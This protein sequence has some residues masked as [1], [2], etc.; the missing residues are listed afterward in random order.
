MIICKFRIKILTYSQISKNKYFGGAWLSH[1]VKHVTLD[2][3]VT[4]SN[5][6]LAVKLTLKKEKKE[7]V[8]LP[9]IILLTEKKP[10]LTFFFLRFSNAYNQIRKVA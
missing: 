3:G 10:R 6:M 5:P 2:L 1:S 4:S 7:K 9:K 8:Y